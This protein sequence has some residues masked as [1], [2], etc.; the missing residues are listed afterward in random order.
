MVISELIL[1]YDPTNTINNKFSVRTYICSFLFP[2]FLATRY[3]SCIALINCA[4]P[5]Q[6]LGSSQKKTGQ[7]LL[8]HSSDCLLQSSSLYIILEYSAMSPSSNSISN[9]GLPTSFQPRIPLFV[10]R[11]GYTYTALLWQRKHL[12]S[13]VTTQL[14][15]A[16]CSHL[17]YFFLCKYAYKHIE[18]SST[19]TGKLELLSLIQSLVPHHFHRVDL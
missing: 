19:S 8:S 11:N 6:Q 9:E 4:D 14:L 16:L 10:K 15:F 18:V 1:P 7:P 2:L 13:S 3:P 12:G 5:L 17:F